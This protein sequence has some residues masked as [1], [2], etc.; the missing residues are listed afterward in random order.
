[1]SNPTNTHDATKTPADLTHDP[2]SHLHWLEFAGKPDVET[3]AALK[4]AGWRWGGYRKAWYSA[5]TVP[6]VPPCVEATDAG[7]VH[8]AAERADRL[9]ARAQKHDAKAT[10]AYERSNRAVEHIPLGQPIL[11]GDASRHVHKHTAN[12]FWAKVQINAP[13][14]CWPWTGPTTPTGYGAVTY[15]KRSWR[16]HRLAWTLENGPIPPGLLV[17]HHCDN[18]PCCN[19]AHLFLGT[20]ADNSADMAAKGRAASGEAHGSRTHP[21]RL[22]RGDQHPARRHPENMARGE[23]NG[24]AV[25]TEDDVREIL[26]RHAEGASAYRLAK[27]FGVAKGTVQFILAGKTWRH[28]TTTKQEEQP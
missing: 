26:R 11:P 8:Y 15:H 7:D 14:Q 10:A 27:D 12:S 23:S 3:R 4:Y 1:M 19:P 5:R 24:S 20:A 9:E 18:P 22:P 21:N 25:L 17:L 16:A 6:Q 13:D 28:I 2:I